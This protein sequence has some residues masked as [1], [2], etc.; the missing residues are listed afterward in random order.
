MLQ[1][2]QKPAGGVTLDAIW[3][4]LTRL[5]AEIRE[6]REHEVDLDDILY[7]DRHNGYADDTEYLMSNPVN[8]EYLTA[9]INDIN[10]G[11]TVSVPIEQFLK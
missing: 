8:R 4:F 7:G 1:T 5:D 11:N 9:A 10:S 3:D 2:M 6:I